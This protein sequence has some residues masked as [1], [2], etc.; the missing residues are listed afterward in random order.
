MPAERRQRLPWLSARRGGCSASCTSVLHRAPPSLL[1]DAWTAGRCRLPGPRL[2]NGPGTPRTAA[3]PCRTLPAWPPEHPTLQQAPMAVQGWRFL[4]GLTWHR[5]QLSLMVLAS[6]KERPAL[7]GCCDAM[8]EMSRLHLPP[9]FAELC[10]DLLG[11]GSW[12]IG[13]LLAFLACHRPLASPGW[14]D[15]R[16]HILGTWSAHGRAAPRPTHLRHR[17]RCPGHSS[18]AGASESSLSAKGWAA[19]SAGWRR[20][21]L[22][23][24]RNA[25]AQP[26]VRHDR[27]P[28][29][30]C[31]RQWC[32]CS[33]R[34]C[35]PPRPPRTAAGQAGRSCPPC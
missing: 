3:A 29:P 6:C 35:W 21:R 18:P 23:W 1:P 7:L 12:H 14:L 31:A 19:R 16:P 25:H 5:H 11:C 17:P 20:I 9:V 30:L 26:H 27:L 15:P 33:R 4:R 13:I 34:G 8:T 22:A 32:S 10:G 28:A 2:T 24:S